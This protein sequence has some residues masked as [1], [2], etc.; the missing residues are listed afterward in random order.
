MSYRYRSSASSEWGELFGLTTEDLTDEQ[1]AKIK[2]KKLLELANMDPRAERILGDKLMKCEVDKLEDLTRL[3]DEEVK[4]IPYVVEQ[5]NKCI[6]ERSK[7]IED[8]TNKGYYNRRDRYVFWTWLNKSNKAKEFARWVDNKN[9]VIEEHKIN[10]PWLYEHYSWLADKVVEKILNKAKGGY[11]SS[12]A[13][14]MVASLPEEP[15]QRYVPTIYEC[16]RNVSV[17]LLSNPHTPRYYVIK[18]LREIAGKKR[19]PKLNVTLDKSMLLELPP[20]MRLNLLE[21]LLIHMRNGHVKFADINNEE[22]LKPLLFG[23]AIKYNSRVEYV[24]KRFKYLCS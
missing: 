14:I 5:Y 10:Y 17:H 13:V 7:A 12:A 23:T 20:V 1:I 16:P 6:R 3:E 9:S 8:A 24:V 4:Q 2:F 19:I 22:E 21:S 15:T 11:N 18:S